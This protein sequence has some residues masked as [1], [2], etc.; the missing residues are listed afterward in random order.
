M[1]HLFCVE[2]IDRWGSNCPLGAKMCFFD[3]K[4]WI[5][6]AK[7][8]FFV[9][10]LRFLS[11]G[12]ITNVPRA[13]TFPFGPPPKKFVFPSYGSFSRVQPGFWSFRA[14]V[15]SQSWVP[16]ILDR[17]QQN[18]VEQ[19]GPSKYDPKWQWTWSRPELRRNGRFYI[20]RKSGFWAK[21]AYF[22]I[23]HPKFAKR[24]IFIQEK[25]TFFFAQLCPVVV[26]TWCPHCQ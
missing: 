24:L 13:T 1:R 21:N 8:Q 4:I 18:F 19:S 20:R 17:G 16:L 15:T 10:E 9:L 3:P 2:N 11:I 12:H 7:S 25:G 22:P 23:K 6:G 5:F 14:C 26:S